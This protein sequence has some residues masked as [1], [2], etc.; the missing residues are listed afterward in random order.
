MFSSGIERIDTLLSDTPAPSIGP[1]EADKFAVGVIQDLLHCWY[2]K[3]EPIKEY[4][5]KGASYR[6][7][8]PLFLLRRPGQSEVYGEYGDQT[9]ALVHAFQEKW[10]SYESPPWA[11]TVD[12]KVDKLTL[13]SMLLSPGQ[14]E[15][16]VTP[17]YFVFVKKKKFTHFLKALALIASQECA[18]KF[19]TTNR[20]G[21]GAGLSCGV[22]H[23]AQKPG[24]LWELFQYF[25]Q[26]A[27]D[28]LAKL[29]GDDQ[30]SKHANIKKVLAHLKQGK[31]VLYWEKNLPPKE[32]KLGDSIDRNMEFARLGIGEEKNRNWYE[33]FLNT[34]GSELFQ[35]LM[36]DF[37]VATLH[38][39]YDKDSPGYPFSDEIPGQGLLQW[40]GEKIKS[41]KGVIFTLDLLN[42]H[43]K[44]P[45]KWYAEFT[46]KD[47]DI[48]EDELLVKFRER[49]KR[50]WI[51]SKPPE[52]KK[53]P[54][55]KQVEKRNSDGDERR[56]NFI[57]HT[58][59]TDL[60]PFD[61]QLP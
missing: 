56:R 6:Q 32:R 21:D 12:G 13:Q 38:R 51:R 46:A 61:P 45:K 2:P 33:C 1:G 48:S 15:P 23:W 9:T 60:K 5:P 7:P 55:Q 43:G 8:A 29:F 58:E 36:F 24:R 42:Q 39:M 16:F 3:I 19:T 44:D 50:S 41:E 22:V 11:L 47:P 20:N 54:N 25:Y 53:T 37:A 57:L 52:D 26:Q 28:E 49:A 31:K 59:Y 34:L 17:G 40:G 27:P 14:L 4:L 10:N 18:C 30:A 35:G